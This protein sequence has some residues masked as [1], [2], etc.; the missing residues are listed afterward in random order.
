M[1]NITIMAVLAAALPLA[2]CGDK[3][4]E[5]K[6]TAV[7]SPKPVATPDKPKDGGMSAAEVK[8]FS[9]TFEEAMREI[10]PELRNDFQKYMECEI[11]ANAKRPP[12]DQKQIDGSRVREMTKALQANRALAS[13]SG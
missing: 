4:P 5:P 2:A 13:C 3:Q 7:A 6:P 9:V 11:Q 12:A 10:P 1:K 8:Q